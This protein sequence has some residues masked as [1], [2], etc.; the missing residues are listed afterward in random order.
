MFHDEACGENF[1][2]SVMAFKI[3]RQ[4]YYW[5]KMFKDT[6]SWV[7][8]CE[9][10]KMF[11]GRPQLA[12]LPLKPVII[13]GLFQQ[14]GL[15]FIG[16]INLASNV[17][18]Q[19]IIATTNY[20]TKWLEAK[21]KKTTTSKVVCEFLKE[22]ILVRFGVPIKLV[23]DNATYFSSIEITSFC[24]EYG[25]IASHSSNYFPLG[26]SQAESSNKNLVNMIK[27]L[28]SDN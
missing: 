17:G 3:L 24:F 8:K 2:S 10:C 1:S 5:P 9:K 18:H 26:N 21:P 4:C 27:K 13:E 28:V 23:M 12:V 19:Y 20:F 11:V 6:Y 25:I 22:S 16:P 15:D 7:S 14:W